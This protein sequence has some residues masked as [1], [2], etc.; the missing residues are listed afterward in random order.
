ML[1]FEREG[2]LRQRRCTSDLS[3]NRGVDYRLINE[4]R[5]GDVEIVQRG[6]KNRRFE[7]LL[8]E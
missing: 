1:L 7:K 8:C 6:V 4:W 5:G 2:L 3:Y